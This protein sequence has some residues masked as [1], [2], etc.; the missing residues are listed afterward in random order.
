MR[1]DLF[2]RIMLAMI[3]IAL[4]GL[5]LTQ[6]D[7]STATAN[8]KGAPG[9]GLLATPAGE[10]PLPQSTAAPSKFTEGAPS[11]SLATL[12]IVWRVSFATRETGSNSSCN[13]PIAIHNPSATTANVEVEWFHSWG[14][15]LPDIAVRSMAPAT[16]AS[17]MSRDSV[18]SNRVNTNPFWINTNYSTILAG[19]F[20]GYAYVYSDNPR[21]IVSAF[22]TCRT[23]LGLDSGVDI[24]SNANV[25]AYPVGMALEYFQA[26]APGAS[27]PPALVAEPGE[28]L[29]SPR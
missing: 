8:S 24:V 14:A 22:V 13:T 3:V 19:D 15:P 12:P 7:M 9:E 10:A 6:A 23:D 28:S 20:D 2:T 25:P 5:L 17:F 27:I 26:G 1:Q 4:W 11:R 16:I 21:I 29:R 18:S